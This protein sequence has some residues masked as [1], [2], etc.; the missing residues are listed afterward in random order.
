MR[1]RTKSSGFTDNVYASN[2]KIYCLTETWLNDTIVS[3]NHFPVSYS[4]FRVDTDYL[5]SH[6]TRVGVVVIEVSNLLQGVMR[7]YDPETTKECVWIVISVSDNFSLIIGIRYFSP[8]CNV[9]ITD[10]CLNVMEQ[11]LNAH[12]C[13]VI[14]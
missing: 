7:R 4:V 12:Q 3:S 2:H 9:T 13:P 10:N 11:T 14:M 5:N 8:D 1:L 6:V